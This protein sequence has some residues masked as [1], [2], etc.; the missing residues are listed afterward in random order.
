MHADDVT[1]D[2]PPPLHPL[3]ERLATA[4]AHVKLV[5]VSTA[6]CALRPMCT[7]QLELLQVFF[8]MLPGGVWP[9]P[10]SSP[11]APV[12]TPSD[13][14]PGSPGGTLQSS[15]E[16]SETPWPVPG[17]S[18]LG[19]TAVTLS[20]PGN[21]TVHL[22][23]ALPVCVCDLTP[24][25]C[26]IN[27][28][29]D[30]DCYLL[31]PRT[32]FS[33]CLPGS[34]RSSSW[35]CVDNS[36]I[37]RSNSPFPSRVF[38]DSSGVKQFCVLA[39]N[40]KLNYFQKLQKV[41][42]THFEALAT[43]FGG[44]SF[45]STIQT[46]SPPP[47]YKAGDPILTYF[48][49]WSVISL[50]RQPAGVGAGGFCAESNP[51]GFLESKSTTCARFFKNLTSSCTSDPV[52]NA[53]SYYNFTVLKVPRGMTDLQ[54]M[55][56]QVPVTLVSQAGS[57][58]LSGNTC[59]NVVSQVIYEIETNGTLGIQKVS[60][61]F[62]Q[63]NLTIEPGTSLQQHFLIRF[64]AFQQNKAASLTSLRSGNPGYIVGKPLLALT[65]DTSHSITLMQSKG[66]GICSVKRHEVQFG[67][68]AISG[69]KFRLK[70]MDCSH[71]QQEIYETLHGKTSPEHVA[72]FG[73]AD[74]AQKREWMR[75][76]SR[77][78]SVSAMHCTSCCVIPVSL[79]IQ[80]LWAY[81]GLQSN[82][83]AHVSGTRFLYQCQSIKDYQ[84]VT[85]VPLT[86]VVTFVDITQ[87]PEPPRGQPR[88]DWK[89]PF[90][91]FFP[92]KVAFS[93]GVDSQKGSASPIL[94]LCL[95][96]LG[97]LKLDTM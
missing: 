44:G 20:A 55:K 70:K 74:P 81:I 93:R 19:P 30:K 43:E 9:Q 27:C 90:D 53:A 14:G 54:N 75:I 63:T 28:C 41:N 87:K 1:R 37:F 66:D 52:L 40:S 79:K 38:M 47:H 10:A 95:L 48:P 72:I 17:I 21:G 69:C 22:F 65:G 68:N 78:C 35:M 97:V 91:F 80:V 82:P 45:T 64:R 12:P 59:Q 86:T 49:E 6:P 85:E 11:S 15:S 13:A 32:V 5:G 25:T 26:D 92:F 96:V 56:F 73:N 18:T 84:Q 3:A 2:A 88:I 58:L 24:G 77:N 51:A 34:V 60:V 71:L 76:L 57:P 62:G 89:L 29:C 16:G 39:N 61:S 4:A 46:Q 42:A 50:L 8:L 31:H 23:P 94:I 67:V 36:L 7:S 83:Q 33:F